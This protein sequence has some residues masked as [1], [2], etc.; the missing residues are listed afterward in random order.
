MGNT[1]A[2]RIK[3][4]DYIRVADEKSCMPFIIFWKMKLNKGVNGGRIKLL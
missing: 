4:Y 1:D 3:L 2:I